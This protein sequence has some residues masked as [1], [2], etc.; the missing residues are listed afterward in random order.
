MSESEIETVGVTAG[1][2]LR[3]SDP[4]AA[5]QPLGVR[6]AE[7]EESWRGA[8]LVALPVIACCAGFFVRGYEGTLAFFEDDAQYYLVIAE[9]LLRTGRS[10]FDGVT[11]TTGYHPLWFACDLALAWGSGVNRRVYVG[12]LLIASA[13]L[14]IWHGAVLR[15]LLA[16]M[17][18]SVVVCDVVVVLVVT[19]SLKIA[20]SGMECALTMPLLAGCALE[21]LRQLESPA[22]RAGRLALLGGLGAVLTLSRLDALPFGVACGALVLMSHPGGLA[23]FVARAAA[24]LA[25]F[26]PL[27]AY[28]LLNWRLTGSAITTSAQ[29]KALASGL[30]WNFRIFD[31]WTSGDRMGLLFVSLAGGALVACPWAPWRGPKRRLALLILGFP[32]VYY[33]LVGLRSSWQIWSWYMYPLPLSAAVAMAAFANV[34]RR[35]VPWNRV[36]ASSVRWAVPA[37]LAIALTTV[38]KITVTRGNNEGTLR[39]ATALADFSTTHPG[40]YAM[41]DRAGL[42][43]LLVPRS[44]L[45][46][47]GLV[48]DESLLSAIRAQRSLQ[49]TLEDFGVDYLVEAIP[50]ATLEPGPCQNFAEPKP[51]QS[52]DRSPKMRGTFCDPLFRY[53]D[54]SDRRTTLVYAVPR[55]RLASP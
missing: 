48:A 24:F 47:E 51:V 9:N 37:S 25:G 42:T 3:P 30:A 46:L 10:T 15:R 55:A 22:I 8:W 6:S 27:G 19:R 5:A 52:G 11:T 39:A 32:V 12:A 16:R 50:T 26:A 29:A 18:S 20:F 4:D 49:Q 45:Q 38:Y 31:N 17:T 36:V 1:G 34:T 13:V 53:D 43:A 44:F 54:S 41:G 33:G 2:T 7:R 40:R 14:A 21:T 35:L 23:S 28:F